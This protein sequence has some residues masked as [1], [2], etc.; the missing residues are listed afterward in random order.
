MYKLIL[1]ADGEFCVHFK[2]HIDLFSLSCE[3][4]ACAENSPDGLNLIKG[5]KPDIVLADVNSGGVNLLKEIK[6]LYPKPLIILLSDEES[7][8]LAKEAVLYD[9]FAYISKKGFWPEGVEVLKRA[10]SVLTVDTLYDKLLFEAALLRKSK[11]DLIKCAVTLKSNLLSASVPDISIL[12]NALYTFISRSDAALGRSSDELRDKLC[13]MKTKEEF[14]TYIDNILNCFEANGKK[15]TASYRTQ[16]QV[17]SY[18]DENYGNSELSTELLSNIFNISPNYLR[19][20]FKDRY[21]ETIKS[22]ITRIRMEKAKELICTRKYKV[23]EVANSV[24]FKDLSQFRKTYKAYF[25][26]TPSSS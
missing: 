24:G 1:I 20:T 9:A 6:W 25:N 11:I 17:L 10:V 22:Y 13:S 5:I 7:L 14:I 18:I 15:R 2:A 4:S 16:E 3:L 21:N 23:Y 8:S 12:Q 19:K 26:S